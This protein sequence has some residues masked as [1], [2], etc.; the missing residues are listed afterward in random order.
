[1]DNFR[2]FVSKRGDQY[3]FVALSLSEQSPSIPARPRFFADA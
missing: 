1:M 3:R 2:E